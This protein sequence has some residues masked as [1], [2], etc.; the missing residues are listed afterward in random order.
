ME[1]LKGE[2]AVEKYGE[3]AKNGVVL[4][5]TKNKGLVFTFTQEAAR[6]FKITRLFILK[7]SSLLER[8]QCF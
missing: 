7:Q 8:S 4:I 3:K 1:V 6:S 2:K 5:T